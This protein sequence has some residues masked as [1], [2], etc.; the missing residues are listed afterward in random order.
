[1]TGPLLL[2]TSPCRPGYAAR[3]LWFSG[4]QC[5]DTKPTLWEQ[6]EP[7]LGK[8]HLKSGLKNGKLLHGPSCNSAIPLAHEVPVVPGSAAV[9]GKYS[10]VSSTINLIAAGITK[11][12]MLPAISQCRWV[13][14]RGFGCLG[15][16][17]LNLT[18]LDWF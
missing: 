5:L 18:H 3:T 1:M 8:F 17:V 10:K 11:P 6:A 7:L 9:K 13:E 4:P 14:L 2:H 15:C 12:Q 16:V